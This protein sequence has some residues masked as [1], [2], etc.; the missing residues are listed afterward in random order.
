MI[1]FRPTFNGMYSDKQVDKIPGGARLGFITIGDGQTE[2]L[3]YIDCLVFPATSN[4]APVFRAIRNGPQ[5]DKIPPGEPRI[6]R[7]LLDA[8]QKCVQLAKV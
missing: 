8:L 3:V 4:S 5:K 6:M 7:S 2:V 1:H